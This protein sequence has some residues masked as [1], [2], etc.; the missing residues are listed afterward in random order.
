MTTI[1]LIIVP[2]NEITRAHKRVTAIF[3]SIINPKFHVE[4]LEPRSKFIPLVVAGEGDD[5]GYVKDWLQRNGLKYQVI[6]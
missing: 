4:V 1:C 3:D 6:K 5:V 2:L